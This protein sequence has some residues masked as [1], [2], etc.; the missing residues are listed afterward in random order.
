MTD[1]IMLEDTKRDLNNN[2]KARILIKLSTQL[3]SL[4]FEGKDLKLTTEEKFKSVYLGFK[5]TA[6][7]RKQM[8]SYVY[9]A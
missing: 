8:H 6:K 2:L 5:F 4:V 3:N 7:S 9:K 1:A